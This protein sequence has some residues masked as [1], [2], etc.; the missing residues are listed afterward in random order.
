MI[1]LNKSCFILVLNVEEI[2]RTGYEFGLQ[3]SGSVGL[4]CT[5][6]DISCNTLALKGTLQ[7]VFTFTVGCDIL[8][9]Y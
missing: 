3:E 7:T 8:G 2:E 5:V 4:C 1:K 6:V 9:Q